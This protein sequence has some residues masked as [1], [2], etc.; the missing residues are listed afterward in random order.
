M[1]INLTSVK[2]LFAETSLNI[3]SFGINERLDANFIKKLLD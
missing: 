1:I 2:N 3:V